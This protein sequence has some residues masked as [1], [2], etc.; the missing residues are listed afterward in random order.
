MIAIF[1]RS[2]LCTFRTDTKKKPKHIFNQCLAYDKS[3]SL[4]KSQFDLFHL[5]IQTIA[6][7]EKPTFP[8]K[9]R[10]APVPVVQ[11]HVHGTHVSSQGFEHFEN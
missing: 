3:N 8:E 2:M 10:F 11:L 1:V 5:T 9:N 4:K 6:W 7:D